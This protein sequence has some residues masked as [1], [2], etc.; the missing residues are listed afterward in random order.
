MW[1]EEGRGRERR[2]TEEIEEEEGGE[3]MRGR[4]EK[5]RGRE[6]GR[7]KREGGR[8][9]GRERKTEKV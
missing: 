6:E 9:C 7:R 1:P 8:E 3:K 2:E 4:E 5:E